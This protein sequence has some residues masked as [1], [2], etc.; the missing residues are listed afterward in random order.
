L[1][2][3]VT[4]IG[5]YGI[6]NGGDEAILLSMINHLKKNKCKKINV[7]SFNK[8]LTSRLIK[9][10]KN[11][12]I[13]YI[14]SKF[15]FIKTEFKRLLNAIKRSEVILVGGGG[16][17]Q[18]AYNWYTIPFFTFLAAL[19]KIF[20]KTGFYSVGVGPINHK[21]NKR[22][23]K[24]IGN[25]VDFIIVRDFAS[26]K[27]LIQNKVKESLIKIT[28]DPAIGLTTNSKKGKEIFKSKNKKRIGV[29]IREV[30]QWHPLNI[31][32][33]STIFDKLIEN[34]KNYEL[35]FIPIGR[36]N[37]KWI[38]NPTE[39]SDLKISEKIIEKMKKKAIIIKE[40][41]EPQEILSVFKEL[42]LV[43][44]MRLHGCILSV[45][46]G[47]PTIGISYKNDN[48]IK[49]FL[50]YADLSEQF[51]DLK[52]LTFSNLDKKI[53]KSFNKKEKI[54]KINKKLKEKNKETL[55]IIKNVK[56]K[57]INFFH[58]LDFFVSWVFGTSLY[59]I[60]GILTRNLLLTKRN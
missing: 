22:L 56:E 1:F 39:V 29:C 50:D 35:I 20:A 52:N 24:K 7:V 25:L 49:S 9:R 55:N 31:K 21:F 51:L 59:I 16:M 58:F 28:V 18:D 14:G 6:G 60:K 2:K 45:N 5:W 36:Y 17:L 27:T 44:S 37:N 3:E 46:A 13:I 30:K 48:K 15:N 8:K 34:N 38:K 57:K 47:V 10:K 40:Y 23:V 11:I 32:K 26:K 12:S 43:I 53:K 33:I 19:C 54:L 4:I 41:L 42:D